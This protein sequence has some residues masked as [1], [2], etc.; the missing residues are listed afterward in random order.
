MLSA[1]LGEAQASP[2]CQAAFHASGPCSPEE[3]LAAVGSRSSQS[4]ERFRSAVQG[5]SESQVKGC[6]PDARQ[7][8]QAK[9]AGTAAFKADKSVESALQALNWYTGEPCSPAAHDCGELWKL[10]AACMP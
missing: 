7:F 3:V 6:M 2:Q 8:M 10:T 5:I 1:L 9:E 4:G